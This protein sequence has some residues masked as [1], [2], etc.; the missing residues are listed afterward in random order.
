MSRLRNVSDKNSHFQTPDLNELSQRAKAIAIDERKLIL[1]SFRETDLH[2]YLRELFKAMEPNYVIE[3]T[4]GSDELGKDLVIVKRDTITVDVIGVVVK[5]GNI[6]AK[7]LGEVDDTIGR[8]NS[9]LKSSDGRKLRELQSQIQQSF[10]H[11][12][13]L[14]TIFPTLPINKVFVILAGEISNRGRIRLTNE[15]TGPVEVFDI[16]WLVDSFTAF[17]PQ[18]F[19]EGKVTDF[20]QNKIQELETQSWR[21]KNDKNLSDCFVEPLVRNVDVPLK[22]NTAS[23]ATALSSKKLPFSK[24]GAIIS[25][26][27]QVILIGDPGTGKSAALAKL[28]IEM[29]KEAYKHLT[30]RTRKTKRA[31]VPIFISAKDFWRIESVQDLLLFYFGDKQILDRVDTHILMLDALDEVPALHRE[32]L[33]K[34]AQQFS[35]QLNSSLILTS[36]KIDLLDSPP[37]G[38]KKYELLPFEAHQALR[39]FEKIHGKDQLLT[40]LKT[41]LNNIKFQ[42]P[43]FPLSLILLIELVEENREVPASITELYERFTDIILGRFDK[44]KGIE[45]L[46]EYIMKKRFLAALAYNEFLSKRR[47]EVPINDYQSYIHQYAKTYT[48]KKADLAN[49]IREVERAGILRVDESEVSFGHR[50]FLDYFAG[51][52]IFDRRDQLKGIESLLVT[53]YFDDLWGDTVFFYIGHKKEISPRLIRKIFAYRADEDLKTDL[54]KFLS[55]RLL[56]AGWYSP[57]KTKVEGIQRAFELVPQLRQEVLTFTEHTK[58]QFPKIFSDLY[59]LLLADHCFTSSFV[60]RELKI[61]FDTMFKRKTH[62]LGMLPLLWAMRE[63]ITQAEMADSIKRLLNAIDKDTGLKSE[64][65]ARALIVMRVLERNDKALVKSI[66]RKINQLHSK[67]PGIFNKLLPQPIRGYRP[68]QKRDARTKILQTR[69][70]GGR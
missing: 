48:L 15:V 4:H 56:Q 27:K 8:V 67:N 37:V 68:L 54:A 35:D 28:S 25:S 52:Y 64:E 21:L 14:K 44:K 31:E 7:T 65:K 16:N 55:G 39:L 6:M 11:P 50:S 2:G 57:T 47:L 5:R 23:L 66:Q 46:F 3:I 18:V 62:L 13:E 22:G 45:V 58:W 42:I 1:E 63:F 34:K 51:F 19:F 38:F 59:L 9:I 53:R 41:E 17:Y 10:A 49:F 61:A 70:F 32:K 30:K 36:R 24:L 29:L 33:I 12:A 60:Q 40:S 26:H 20:I 43:M 69:A